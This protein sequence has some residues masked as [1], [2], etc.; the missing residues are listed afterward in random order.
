MADRRYEGA[1]DVLEAR[2]TP[3]TLSRRMSLL[4]G[5]SS[6]VAVLSARRRGRG[7]PPQVEAIL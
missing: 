6:P 4:R 3:V 5:Q 1:H 7:G 2:R